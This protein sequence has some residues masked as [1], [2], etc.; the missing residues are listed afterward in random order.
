[1]RRLQCLLLPALLIATSATVLGQALPTAS[2]SGILSKVDLGAA[3]G[4]QFTTSVTNQTVQVSPGPAQGT[5]LPHYATGDSLAGLVTLHDQPKSWA[6]FELNYQYSRYAN[7]FFVP[8]GAG[9]VNYVAQTAVH[10]GTAAYLVHLRKMH[11]FSPYVGIGGGA[12]DF[13]PPANFH[14]QWRGA[15]LADIG[16]DMQTSS[17]LGFRLG[18]RDLFYRAPN[19]SSSVLSSSRWVSSEEPYV[20]MY[21]KF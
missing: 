3:A 7:R 9:Q 21:V 14:H 5:P 12:L 6:G 16:F 10:E 1:M 20:G 15:A 13:Q 11:R 19:F 17:R 2:R 8:T 18:A 4:G